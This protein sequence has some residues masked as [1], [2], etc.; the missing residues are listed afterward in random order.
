[1]NRETERHLYIHTKEGKK[2]GLWLTE[3]CHGQWGS[4]QGAP[5]LEHDFVTVITQARIIN[6]R[7]I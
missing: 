2:R 7:Q 4:V 5:E 6:T 3:E 1:M